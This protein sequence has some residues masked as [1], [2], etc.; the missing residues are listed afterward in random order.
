MT[1]ELF[2]PSKPRYD[3]LDGLRGVAA[4]V[5]LLYHVLEGCGV[6]LG[7]GYLG[8]DF[9]Y[10]LSGFV[11]GYAY[12]DRWGRMNVGGFFKRRII[13]LH[14]MV[15]MGTA[16]GLALYYFQTSDA[17]PLI[18]PRPWWVGASAFLLLLPDAP[19]AQRVGHSRL[20]GHQLVQREHMVA[21]LGILSEHLLR[22]LSALRAHDRARRAHGCGGR[23]HARPHAE[24]QSLR[25][26]QRK[27]G[28]APYTVNGGWSLA[29]SEL[30]VGA[31]RLGYPFL[32][33]MMLSRTKRLVRMKGGFVW[34]ALLV[35]ALLLMPAFE[36]IANGVYE[37]FAILVI[38]PLIVSIGAGSQLTGRKYNAACKFLGDL[39]YPLYITHLPVVS[40]QIAYV[41][42]HPEAPLSNLIMVSVLTF[43]LSV[44]VAYA[45]LKLYDVPVRRWLQQK[46]TQRPATCS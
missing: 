14:P 18:G 24:P 46:W 31:V 39:S 4:L 10:V 40:L 34:T 3:I 44:A 21:L 30:Y 6:V 5:I 2:L 41:S 1:K 23:R 42:N 15:I 12:D 22:L 20:A 19:D 11:I 26:H 17:L 32:V 16:I 27:Q 36:G 7:H 8:V 45:C 37:A 9:F 35:A 43:F 38:M 29:P 28:C 33:G 13:R 25:T